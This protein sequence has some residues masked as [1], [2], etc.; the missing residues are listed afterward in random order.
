MIDTHC[1]LTDERLSRQLPAVLER[2]AAAGVTRCITIGTDLPDSEAARALAHAHPPVVF[3]AG[4]HPTYTRPYTP[5]DVERLRPLLADGRC[6]AL[7]EIGLDHYWKDVP[8]EHQREMFA[9]Q[10]ALAAETGKPVI[11]HSREAVDA[12]LAVL[13]DFPAVRAVFH[14]FGG[15]AEQARA[16]VGAGYYIGLDG[17]LTYRNAA[18]VRAV[19]AVV[20]ADRL[21]L[22]TDCPY[23]TPEPHRSAGVK[24]NEPAYVRAVAEALAAVRGCTLDDIDRQTTDNARRLFGPVVCA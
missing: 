9:A 19:A 18:A 12:T 20:P 17:P 14:C 8:P 4:I 5:A 24:V 2:A 7:G 1:H 13:R 23:L 6:V 10:L 15:S 22:E 11:L 3:A 16:V 21:L